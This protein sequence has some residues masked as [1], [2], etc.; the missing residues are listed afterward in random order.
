[1]SS[2]KRVNGENIFGY[3]RYIHT[4]FRVDVLTSNLSLDS[5]GIGIQ[6]KVCFPASYISNFARSR[7]MVLQMAG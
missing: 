5:C 4:V 6:V 3:I 2:Q 1:M 7:L